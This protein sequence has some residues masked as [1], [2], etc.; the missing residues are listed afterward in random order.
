MQRLFSWA[1]L[2]LAALAALA[3][4]GA[5][6][7]APAKGKD[8]VL[9]VQPAAQATA[10]PT[11]PA[12]P[13][14]VSPD[15]ARRLQAAPAL[16]DLGL[17]LARQS[18]QSRGNARANFV[19][20]PYSV[21]VTLGMLHAG[22]AGKTAADIAGVLEPGAT[23]G[24]LLGSGLARL[25][26]SIK[27]DASTQWL[28][29][30]RL[31]VASSMVSTLSPVFQERLRTLYGADGATLDFAAAAEP[32]RAAI[33]QWTAGATQNLLP[34]LLPAGSIR[35]S[36]RMVLTNAA[37]FKGE[38]ATPFDAAST[39]PGNFAAEAG[40]RQVPTMR[41]VM[42]VREGTIDNVFVLELPFEGGNFSMLLALPPAGH[43]LQALE[44]DLLGA[45][46]AGWAAQLK[47]QRVQL[48]LPKFEVRGAVVT[49]DDALR[50]A[51]MVTPFTDAADFSGI[52]G[53]RGIRLD[54]VFHSASI[55]VNEQGTVATAAT[56]A[57]GVA[58][59]LQRADLPVRAFDRPFL[60]VLLHKP[61]ATP[62]FIG[63]VAEPA[64]A[65]SR[66]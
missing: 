58:K 43:T 1:P 3:V 39:V 26:V 6:A 40:L 9:D 20:S 45:D 61:T 56:A 25:P 5:S 62:L 29:P 54:N 19:V 65:G 27:G 15:A 50:A 36:T 34:E 55:E 13:A 60:F 66:S 16:A 11:A 42:A 17:H 10:A 21:G 46:L 33:N 57:T 31:W 44:N 53:G 18:S 30:S 12:F 28:S 35:P 51:G 49:L 47:P 23:G 59:S 64:A 8:I 38:W 48:A 2:S 37:Y 4:T 14:S 52:Q 41:G 24:R 7:Q 63:R 22:A 32:A